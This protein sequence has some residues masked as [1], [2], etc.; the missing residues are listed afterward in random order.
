M[1]HF[2]T[3]WRA[4]PAS[5]APCA[6]LQEQLQ[7]GSGELALLLAAL[8]RYCVNSHAC[9]D[10]PEAI[11]AFM[12]RVPDRLAAWAVVHAHG[13]T[14]WPAS[15]GD[16]PYAAAIAVMRV[17]LAGAALPPRSSTGERALHEVFIGAYALPTAARRWQLDRQGLRGR[18]PRLLRSM[19]QGALLTRSEAESALYQLLHTHP[20]A[21][22]RSLPGCEAVAH[23]GGNVAAVRAA[24]RWRHRFAS[25]R[26]RLAA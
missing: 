18:Y 3:S 22:E 2:Q 14:S 21:R 8:S 10:A 19:E 15:Y 17:A 12:Q 6:T 20:D 16:S 9:A 25:T 26:M 4:S 13:K 24:R 11:V 7:G 1:D 5:C 23:F